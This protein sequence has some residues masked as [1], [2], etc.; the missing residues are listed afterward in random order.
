[1]Y[2]LFQAVPDKGEIDLQGLRAQYIASALHSV[3]ISKSIDIINFYCYL[4]HIC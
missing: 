1:M 3:G 4:P 2:D